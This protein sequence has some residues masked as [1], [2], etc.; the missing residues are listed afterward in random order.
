VKSKKGIGFAML[1]DSRESPEKLSS[2]K[3]VI[4]SKRA[5]KKKNRIEAPRRS[6]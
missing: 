4:K 3:R 5:K 1:I 6:S 2:R